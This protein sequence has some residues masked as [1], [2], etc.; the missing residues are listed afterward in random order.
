MSIQIICP[1]GNW[2]ISFLLMN[3]NVSSYFLYTRP[4]SFMWFAIIFF[5]YMEFWKFFCIVSFDHFCCC[6]VTQLLWPLCDPMDCSTPGF[7][8]LHRLLELAQIHVHWVGD[9]I[10]PSH[11]SSP[12]PPAF[13]LSPIF[14]WWLRGQS[15]CQQCRRPGFDPWVGKIPWRR[16]WQPT[17]VLLPKKSHGQRSLVGYSP[18]GLRELDTTEQLQSVSALG[19]FPMSQFFPSGGQSIG[20]SVSTSVLPMN[21][22]DWSPLGWTGLIA[23]V[24][25]GL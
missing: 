7:P 8:V 22:R 3:H 10:Q 20:V 18:W 19:C 17:P 11:L 14:P 1:I 25:K 16:K 9:A 21:T 6:S 24:S 4:S 15:V 23:L 13:S 12:F 5:Y 2:V